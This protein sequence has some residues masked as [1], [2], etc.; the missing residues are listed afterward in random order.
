MEEY[1]KRN[2]PEKKC[3]YLCQKA[4][5][6]LL[7]DV[8]IA[9]DPNDQF[10]ENDPA[11][12]SALDEVKDFPYFLIQDATRRRLAAWMAGGSVDFATEKQKWGFNDDEFISVPKVFL[13][14]RHFEDGGLLDLKHI[15]EINDL[16]ADSFRVRMAKLL[17]VSPELAPDSV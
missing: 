8:E 3:A 15:G 6:V 16:Q 14:Y 10:D 4:A 7:R 17:S 2:L 12:L 11:Y 1:F 9:R 5:Y 13:R